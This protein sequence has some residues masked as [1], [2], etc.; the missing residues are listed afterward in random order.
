MVASS[1]RTYTAPNSSN[2]ALTGVQRFG[3]QGSVL[4]ATVLGRL[5]EFKHVLPVC[6]VGYTSSKRHGVDAASLVKGGPAEQ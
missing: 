5:E 6:T 4:G 3:L 2:P 1:L